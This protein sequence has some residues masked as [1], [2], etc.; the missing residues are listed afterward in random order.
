LLK[1]VNFQKAVLKAKELAEKQL[2]KH[3]NADEFVELG[4]VD[5]FKI[6]VTAGKTI[7]EARLQPL[8]KNPR[9]VFMLIL[10]GETEFTFENAETAIAKENDCFVL[11][12]N[13]NH[14]CVFRK[15]TIAIEGVYEKE[16]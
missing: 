14:R 15:M 10:Q 1:I 11:P 7:E 9:D 8:H 12:K 13:L 4:E 5:G 16:L 6:Y 2:A 3:E